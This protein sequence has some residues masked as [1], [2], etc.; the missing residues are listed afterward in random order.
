LLFTRPIEG[1]MLALALLVWIV[2]RDGT[3]PVVRAGLTMAVGLFPV[4]IVMLLYN[5]STTGNPLRFPLWAIGGNDSFGFGDRSI[6]AGAPTVHYGIGE[7]W[8][9]LRTNLRAFPHWLFGGVVTVPVL[10]WGA[11]RL[12][13]THRAAVAL[14]GAIALI[15]PLGYF[16]YWGNYLIIAGRNFF[17]PHYYLGLLLPATAFIAVAV[18]DLIRRG[19]AL[20]F[21]LVP[22]LLVGT[23]IE[24]RPKID[25]NVRHRDTVDREVAA[26][27]SSVQT[28]AVVVLPVGRD[29]PYVLH[30]RGAFGNSPD[31][32][33][34]TL[35]AVDL[36]GRNLE[37]FDRFPD[38]R[39]YRLQQI[40]DGVGSHPDVRQLT[41]VR[42]AT[43][44]LNL[45]AAA[46]PGQTVVSIYAAAG[47]D[48]K[49]CVLGRNVVPGQTFIRTV[50]ITA[51][52]LTISG[53]EG[54]NVVL[55]VPPA[56]SSV[57]IGV[58]SGATPDPAAGDD[59]EQRV[60]LRPIDDTIEMVTPPDTWHRDDPQS[61][62]SV[63]D[64]DAVPWVRFQ[65]YSFG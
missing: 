30:P 5:R 37:L 16:F 46:K 48:L 10:A 21:L 32:S 38:R 28:P 44:D 33:G 47:G 29:G 62:F 63:V 22:A 43:V 42:A 15:Y 24:V 54:G 51:A 36:L 6:V 40:D 20:A 60:W 59:V 13:R 39:I 49:T 7:A 9:T 14:L 55:A 3:R 52:A 31:L 12:W 34:P 27:R 11:V 19:A 53:C 35:F 61:P 23:A 41:R 1:L 65:S 25:A 2:V 26:V 45:T 17:G 18:D 64:A 8:L 58:N 56:M 50:S 4:V 57:A